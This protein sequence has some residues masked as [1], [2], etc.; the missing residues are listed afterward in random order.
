MTPKGDVISP[1]FWTRYFRDTPDSR[2]WVR[3]G[4]NDIEEMRTVVNS[5]VSYSLFSEIYF[6]MYTLQ[7]EMLWGWK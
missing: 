7:K 3:Y 5:H 4:W 1:G 6:R 2:E